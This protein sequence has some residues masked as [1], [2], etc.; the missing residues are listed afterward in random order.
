MVADLIVVTKEG[1]RLRVGPA[2]LRV[3]PCALNVFEGPAVSRPDEA[4]LQA[5]ESVLHKN[6]ELYRRLA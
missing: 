1:R 5:L 6:A 2:I 4:F 3:I